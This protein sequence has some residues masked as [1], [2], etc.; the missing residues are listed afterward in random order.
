[1]LC[2]LL[3]DSFGSLPRAYCIEVIHINFQHHTF[4][5][6]VVKVRN[7]RATSTSHSID[8]DVCN[9]VTEASRWL[10]SAIKL[11]GQLPG[12]ICPYSIFFPFFFQSFFWSFHKTQLVFTGMEE[13]IFHIREVRTISWVLGQQ[14][15]QN[16]RGIGRASDSED[17]ISVG[18]LP[19]KFTG[20]KPG[21]NNSF[22][23]FKFRNFFPPGGHILPFG[24]GPWYSHIDPI[25]FKPDKLLSL[26]LQAL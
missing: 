17:I 18:L 15:V 9:V 5:L 10:L 8:D 16:S 26:A 22:T 7:L 13:C 20:K 3:E 24:L 2:N 25:V 14:Q 21:S 1:M 12:P 11:F 4:L 23:V 6:I 19:L